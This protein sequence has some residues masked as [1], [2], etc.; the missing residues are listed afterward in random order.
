MIDL[1]NS[2]SCPNCDFDVSQIEIECSNCNYPLAGSEKEKAIFIGRQISNK[3]RIGDAKTAQKK[4][5]AILYIIGGFLLLNACVAL[6]NDFDLVS[7]LF[8]FILGFTMLGFGY[9]SPKKP[10]IF[11]SLALGLL[12]LYYFILY[13]LDPMFLFQGILW[14]FVAVAFLLWGLVQSYSE[15]QLKKKNQFLKH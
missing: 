11:I 5:R 15:H 3:S 8:Y 7:I 13:L 12:I 6:Y 10:L 4:V 1:P 9:L 2:L 14:K